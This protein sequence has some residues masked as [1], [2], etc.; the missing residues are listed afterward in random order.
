M[1]DTNESK[2]D[3]AASA[4]SAGLE[5][6]TPALRV[7]VFP[8]REG[9]GTGNIIWAGRDQGSA[10]Y[11]TSKYAMRGGKF[12]PGHPVGGGVGNSYSQCGDGPKIIA[13]RERGYW[14]SCF[15]EG[16]GITWKPERGQSDDQCM[17]DIRECFGW[18]AIWGHVRSN[19]EW[20]GERSESRSHAGL[21][22]NNGGSNGGT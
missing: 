4:M 3:G 19:V 17:A 12:P 10:Y 15:P 18:D 13:F 7:K 6:G 14:A 5:R 9:L 8:F 22:D 1:T 2:H 21:E 11:R 20:R 16:D